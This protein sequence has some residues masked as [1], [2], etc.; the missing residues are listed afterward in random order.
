MRKFAT[1]AMAVS[2]FIGGVGASFAQSW[3]PVPKM[4][5][6][7][8][9][10]SEATYTWWPKRKSHGGFQLKGRLTDTGPSDGHNVYV[11]AKVESYSWRRF[12]GVQKRSVRLDK[13]LYDGAAQ[14][15]R[16]AWVRA[17]RDR[18]SLRPD[19]CSVTKHYAR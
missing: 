19:N 16:K 8:A 3:H 9:V 15:T 12:N 4:E 13:L 11:Q 18:G 5:T 7:G 1:A 10:F 2:L 17:C 14:H 6:G